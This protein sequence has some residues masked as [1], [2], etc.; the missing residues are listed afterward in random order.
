MSYKH[1]GWKP[2]G[3]SVEGYSVE[4]NVKE[5][6]GMKIDHFIVYTEKAYQQVLKTIK[7]KYGFNYPIENKIS[8]TNVATNIIHGELDIPFKKE[9]L[10]PEQKEDLE[11]LKELKNQ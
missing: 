1:Q 8:I 9:E 2:Y 4:I 7:S 11:M 10:T 3:T 6:S 5:K